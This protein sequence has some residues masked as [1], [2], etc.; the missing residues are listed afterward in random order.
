ML[1]KYNRTRKVHS[2]GELRKNTNSVRNEGAEVRQAHPNK[3]HWQNAVYIEVPY[4]LKVPLHASR[5]TE[6]KCY[7]YKQKLQLTAPVLFLEAINPGT[8][9]YSVL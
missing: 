6:L 3:R 9:C 7:R 8:K 1:S 2:F 5:I 4:Y